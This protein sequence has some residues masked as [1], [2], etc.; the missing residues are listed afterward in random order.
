MTVG[1]RLAGRVALVTGGSRGV[2]RGIALRLAEEGAAIA[3]NYRRDAEA[4]AEVVAEITASGGR[5][6]SYAASVSDPTRC[7]PWLRTSARTW[8]RSTCS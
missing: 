6:V 1:K 3:V 7:G 5:A 8:D 4:V 2:G